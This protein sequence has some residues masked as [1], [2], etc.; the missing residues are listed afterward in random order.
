MFRFLSLLAAA[1]AKTGSGYRKC[2]TDGGCCLRN[3]E[4]VSP[5]V[6]L[7][8]C[9]GFDKCDQHCWKVAVKNTYFSENN[10]RCNA[11]QVV[12]ERFGIAG[13]GWGAASRI[14]YPVAKINARYKGCVSTEDDDAKS[15]QLCYK[16]I[17]RKIFFDKKPCVGASWGNSGGWGNAPKSCKLYYSTEICRQK[18]FTV[19]LPLRKKKERYNSKRDLK[20]MVVP[21]FDGSTKPW[22]RCD[23]FSADWTDCISEKSGNSNKAEAITQA[24]DSVNER[25][26]NSGI[27]ASASLG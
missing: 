9:G 12:I 14:R 21:L 4:L 23:P 2:G 25:V 20:D 7:S 15:E 10:T 27:R 8:Q 19:G 26:P 17:I 13:F 5:S 24:S 16:Q 3:Y 11:K 6:S 22:G 18:V 1:S